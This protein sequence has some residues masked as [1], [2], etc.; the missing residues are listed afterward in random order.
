[1]FG[2]LA[3]RIQAVDYY[4]APGGD[5][6]NP[7]TQAKPFRT[8]SAARD[9]VRRKIAVGL[10]GNIAVFL[11]GGMYRISEPVTFGPQDSGTERFSITYTSVPGEKPVIS[12][13]RVITGWKAGDQGVWTVEIPEVKSGKWTFRELLV[14]GR[15]ARRARHPDEGFF[16]VEKV[17]QDRRTGFQFRAGDH[18]A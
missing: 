1:L 6:A 15:R 4:V 18:H 11:R 12:G 13:G 9:A 10:T 8:I 7:G 14:D 3:F 2:L 5:D 16:R 17:G